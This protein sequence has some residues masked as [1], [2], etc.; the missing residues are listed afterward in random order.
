MGVTYVQVHTDPTMSNA[1]LHS[2]ATESSRTNRRL[3]ARALPA[4]ILAKGRALGFW[5]AIGLPFLYIP[6]LAIGL[7]NR[8][9]LLLFLALLVVHV[10]ALF[11][12]RSHRR[13]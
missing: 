11:A 7:E 9:D 6:L 10:L 4:S 2:D 5:T 1:S 8:H 3:A 12:G 13:S